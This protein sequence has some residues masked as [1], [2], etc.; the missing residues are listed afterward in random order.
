MDKENEQ[1]Q[2]VSRRDDIKRPDILINGKSGSN[3][4]P[5]FDFSLLDKL[6]SRDDYL[7]KKKEEIAKYFKSNAQIQKR[8]SYLKQAYNND[9]SELIIGNK[10][11]GYLK[12][13][14]FLNVWEGNYLTRTA[15]SDLSW[16]L[17]SEYIN[18]M[19]KRG[20]YTEKAENEQLSLFDYSY[21]NDGSY[22]E[23]EYSL[24][25]KVINSVLKSGTN[26]RFGK[27]HIAAE[28]MRQKPSQEIAL[29]LKKEYK[30]GGK[31]FIIDN[32]KYAAWFDENGI[33]IAYGS[34]VYHARQS[35]L[36]S[37][38]DVY[39]CINN[40]LELGQYMPQNQ[41][42]RV[43]GTQ[44]KEAA[45]YLWRLQ[46]ESTNFPINAELF[47]GG[48]PDSTDRID[49]ALENPETVKDYIE[50]LEQFNE[51]YK[52]DPS[53]INLKYYYIDYNFL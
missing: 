24:P 11:V 30:T 21:E 34:S 17:V 47:N 3:K 37:W 31:G 43:I 12:K 36:L 28:F 13:D 2:S 50:K 53:L 10:R 9:Y 51:E 25:D 33:R 15:E 32:T 42:D 20:V 48:F 8:I 44:R 35:V 7:L 22:I 38:E 5:D 49:K 23:T 18:D 19:I 46:R 4:L 26:E 1:Y 14:E 29:F 45:E 27:Y 6:L 41:L 39:D 16:E 52:K 40:L